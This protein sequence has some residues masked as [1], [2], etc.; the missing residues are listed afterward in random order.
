M[1]ILITGANGQLGRC[2]ADCSHAS[3]HQF[4]LFDR[5][6]LDI[7]DRATVLSA[8]H[9]FQPDVII[10]AAAY[11]AVDQAESERH[12]AYLVNAHGV[13]NLARA[14]NA[15]GAWLIHVSTDFVFDGHSG[16]PYRETDK[17]NPLNV[18]GL[19]KLAGE[20]EAAEAHHHLVVRTGWLF[21]E[22]GKNFLTT[23][24]RLAGS[25]KPLRIVADQLGT[26]T[27]AGD[28]AAALIQLSEIVVSHPHGPGLYHFNGGR[29]CSWFEFAGSIFDQAVQHKHLPQAPEVRAITTREYAAPARRP[30]FS[31][32]DDSRLRALLSLPPASWEKVLPKVIAK[33]L[34]NRLKTG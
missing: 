29:T 10:N 3:N 34:S 6:K 16:R 25:Q 20:T 30:G 5:A 28:L 19:S 14:A 4:G 18:Y 13:G 11:T 1:K 24:L 23:M 33:A 17:T 8:V 12:T 21:S 7:T 26:P 2:L 32:M 15:A 31:A 9:D 27:Y 22:Y